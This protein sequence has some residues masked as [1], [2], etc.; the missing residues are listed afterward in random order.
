MVA[1]EQLVYIAEILTMQ[2]RVEYVLSIVLG[3]VNII[4]KNWP[5]TMRIC[6]QE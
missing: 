4:T 6:Y 1:A 3:I 2:D 5:M